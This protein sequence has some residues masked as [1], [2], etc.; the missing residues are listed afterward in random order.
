MEKAPGILFLWSLASQNIIKTLAP[1]FMILIYIYTYIYEIY[2]YEKKKQIAKMH[3]L[4]S[5]SLM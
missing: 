4:K 5:H 3:L 1:K 2:I